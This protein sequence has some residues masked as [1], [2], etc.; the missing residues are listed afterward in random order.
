MGL[1][2]GQCTS[3]ALVWAEGQAEVD[4][5]LVTTS[6]EWRDGDVDRTNSTKNVGVLPTGHFLS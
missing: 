5:E 1:T 6:L 4:R 3:S 2:V